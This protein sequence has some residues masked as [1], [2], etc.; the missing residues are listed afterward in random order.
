[1]DLLPE[2]CFFN[3]EVF[4]AGQPLRLYILIE[5]IGSVLGLLLLGWVVL[6][7]QGEDLGNR[8][9]GIQAKLTYWG[10]ILL[11]TLLISALTFYIEGKMPLL[12]HA[13]IVGI[14]GFLYAWAFV[15]A[16]LLAL[17]RNRAAYSEKAPD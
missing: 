9:K 1:M 17:T 7:Q 2:S 11:L 8:K 16:L 6:S 10:C 3:Q 12:G 5:W 4:V 15:S 14:S 13:F